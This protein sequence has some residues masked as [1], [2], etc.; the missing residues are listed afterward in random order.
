MKVLHGPVN[1]GNQPWVLSRAERALNL[2]SELVV[3]FNTWLNYGA[4]RVLTP[5]PY[6]RD[7]RHRLARVTFGI[8]AALRYD[9]IHYYF[10]Q[11]YI[12]RAGR[13]TRTSFADLKLAKRLGRAV[14]MTLQ[15]CDVRRAG[16]SNR[17][18]A[19]TMCRDGG[20][21]AYAQ[22]IGTLDRVRGQLIE[23]ILP[24]CDRVF[25]LNPELGHE[26]DGRDI[27]ADFLPYAS[28]NI[29]DIM[30]AAPGQR[31]R[32]VILHAPSD[33][34]IKG[35]DLIEAALE[36]LRARFDFDYRPI[37]GVPHAEAMQVYRDA[38]LVI[39]Q[40]QAGWYGGF[41]VEVMAMGKPVAAYIRTE[42]MAHVPAALAAELPVLRVDPRTLE[43]D[44]AAILA[45]RE[46]WAETGRRSRAFVERWHDPARI[47]RGLKRCYE[48]PRAVLDL[49]AA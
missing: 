44:L 39:D 20:C 2:E 29:D 8:E 11:S 1:V 27:R 33:R 36:R 4:D 17:R 5:K 42:D 6:S 10:G 7:P 14:F 23:E 18:N 19:V 41:A 24:L 34:A 3:V 12:Y 13:V 22:C 40:V 47:A 35:S 49:D 25:Y 38:D 15:G 16:P 26:L 43:D 37:T 45:A 32:P 46:T 9:V 48:N 30:P 21:S 31:T 28:C